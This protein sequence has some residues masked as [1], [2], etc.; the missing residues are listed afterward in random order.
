MDGFLC[1]NKPQGPSSF[2]IVAQLRKTLKTRKIGHTGTLDP[3][4]SGLLVVAVGSATR[5]I[6]YLPGEPKVYR[7]G[8]QFGSQTDTL[9]SKG[10]VIA[11]GGI[12]PSLNDLKSVLNLYHGEYMQLPPAFSAKKI[13][14]IRAYQIARKGDTPQLTPCRVSIFSLDLLQY[15][16]F[17]GLAELQLSCS[18][19]TYVR[20]LVRDLASELNTFG[21]AS[22][23]QR[24]RCGNFNIDQAM[25]I[26]DI[27]DAVNY[28]MPAAVVLG[29]EPNIQLSEHLQQ[30][31]IHG[32][33]ISLPEMDSSGIRRIFAYCGTHLLAVLQWQQGSMYHPVAV[34]PLS[35]DNHEAS[36]NR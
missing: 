24:T 8:L 19:G 25:E 30:K 32:M 23:I 21:F 11:F 12:F 34:F 33:D 10:T 36:F 18:G 17:R 22:F 35:G 13:D 27:S 4:A 31:L 16:S 3:E 6:Q 20:A 5:L 29:N 2:Q 7:F 1:V 28:I 15:D 14:G 9:D 26:D